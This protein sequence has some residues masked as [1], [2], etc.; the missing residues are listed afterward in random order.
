L[1]RSRTPSVV[2]WLR[3]IPPRIDASLQ[4]CTRED[5][6]FAHPFAWLAPR[7]L[8]KGRLGSHPARPLAA[9]SCDRTKS[10]QRCFGPTSATHISKTSTRV[11][12]GDR[13]AW[14]D[15]PSVRRWVL[16]FTTLDP[17]WPACPP[18]APGVLFPARPDEGWTSD[19]PSPPDPTQRLATLLRTGR[20][21]SLSTASVKRAACHDPERLPPTGS[22]TWSPCPRCARCHA[23][24]GRRR[25]FARSSSPL[26]S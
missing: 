11:T 23:S 13:L 22:S 20:S 16:R 9:R 18:L 3:G 1:R 25:L 17:L 2:S 19:A 7:R 12:C 14:R 5:R 21:R 10:T 6:S 24:R 15:K 4:G 26:Q 8:V